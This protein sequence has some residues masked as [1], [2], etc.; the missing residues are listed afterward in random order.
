MPKQDRST[1]SRSTA[2]PSAALRRLRATVVGT[3]KLT[4]GAEGEIRYE[5]MEG[6]FFLAQHVNLT[7]FGRNIGGI[8]VIGHLHRIGER[9]TGEI[10]TRF[11]SFLDGLTLDYVYE[12][13]G[14]TPTI[15]FMRKN[16][17]NRFKATFSDNANS[18]KGAWA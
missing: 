13:D 5:W 12:L 10:W 15:W 16:S 11:Y 9:P 2:V 6:G 4:G 17:D 8:E 7:A 3:W 18:F 1:R 14:K